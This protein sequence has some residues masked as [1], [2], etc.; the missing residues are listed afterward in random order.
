MAQKTIFELDLVRI[1]VWHRRC[2][3]YC[4]IVLIAFVGLMVVMANPSVSPTIADVFALFF[5]GLMLLNVFFVVKLQHAC[6]AG[7]VRLIAYGLL[8]FF[9]HFLMLITTVS[10]AGTILRLAG[11]KS[12][13]LGI[14]KDEWEKLRPGHCR[15]CGYSREGLELLQECP[16]CQRVPQVI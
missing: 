13:F 9:L 11:A 8:A 1:A 2:L 3:L 6:G 5:M 4:L 10:G 14:S 12:G 7:I 16:E 15:G